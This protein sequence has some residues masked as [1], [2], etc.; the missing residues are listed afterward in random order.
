M[1]DTRSSSNCKRKTREPSPEITM[2]LTRTR[3]DARRSDATRNDL[4][5]LGVSWGDAER[6]EAMRSESKRR[7]ETRSD[8][9]LLGVRVTDPDSLPAQHIQP[10]ISGTLG[11]QRYPSIAHRTASARDT[12]PERSSSHT[13]GVLPMPVPAPVMRPVD[14]EQPAH[15][16]CHGLQTMSASSI[17]DTDEPL[18]EPT[19]KRRRVIQA[20]INGLLPVDGG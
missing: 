17:F 19:H 12:S 7:E 16:N 3:S 4:E 14:P 13:A 11:M 8:T 20:Q 2:R 9:E 6:L 1:G 15:S 18:Q 5:Q 10:D